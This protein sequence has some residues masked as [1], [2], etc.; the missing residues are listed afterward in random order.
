MMII[1]YWIYIRVEFFVLYALLYPSD[2]FSLCAIL[3]IS[4]VF[5]FNKVINH[6]LRILELGT[7]F[8]GLE[9]N[10]NKMYGVK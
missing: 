1:A 9:G 8:N 4:T 5:N 3:L 6:S 10:C 2:L 7:T